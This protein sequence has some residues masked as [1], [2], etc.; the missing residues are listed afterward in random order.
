V[1]WSTQADS[2]E[3]AIQAQYDHLSWGLYPRPP[4]PFDYPPEKRTFL[5]LY[6]YG[7][8]GIW[9]LV[10]ATNPTAITARY[11]ELD[12][13]PQRPSWLTPEHQ[14]RLA[15]TMHFDIDAP[16]GWLLDLEASRP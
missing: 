6:D 9:V 2:Y 5:L 13:I 8:G 7:Q 4:E 14:R 3:A 10:D 15:G 16:S 1:I 12:L 11:P